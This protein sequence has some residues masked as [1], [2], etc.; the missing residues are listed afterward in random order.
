MRFSFFSCLA[1]LVSH[2]FIICKSQAL[3]FSLDYDNFIFFHWKGGLTS[4]SIILKVFPL[5]SLLDNVLLQTFIALYTK[6]TSSGVQ[7]PIVIPVNFENEEFPV[8]KIKLESLNPNTKYFYSFIFAQSSSF[9]SQTFAQIYLEQTPQEFSFHTLGA[10]FSP[11]NFTF[12]S[13]SC[14]DT[15][16][17]SSIFTTLKNLDLQFF[18][19]LG[20]LHYMNIHENEPERF[21]DAYYKVFS[22]KTQK[23]FLQSTPIFYVWDDH[24]FGPD[25]SNGTSPARPASTTAY[26]KFVPYDTLKNY[27]PIDISSVSLDDYLPPEPSGP[28]GIFRSFVVGRCLFIMMDL[29]SFKDIKPLD[30]LGPEQTVWL[31]NQLK[32]AGKNPH[33]L[34]AFLISSFSWIHI[35]GKTEWRPYKDVQEQISGWIEEYIYGNGKQIMMISGDAHMLALDDGTNNIY[36]HFPVIQT[37][38]LDSV[39][40]CKGG[41]YSHGL[42]SG[43]EHFGLIQVVD[44]GADKICIKINLKEREESLI[45]YD[46]CNKE[47]YPPNQK[48]CPI[49][50]P[51][52]NQKKTSPSWRFFIIAVVISAIVLLF[53]TYKEANPGNEDGRN[54][55]SY[56]EMTVHP[57]E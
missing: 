55:G 42:F 56:V 38:S 26:K 14:A 28:Y 5:Q 22:S 8:A 7:D 54:R 9:D 18:L 51:V 35:D 12:A 47:L 6:P 34:Q 46:T 41:P 37:A 36:G 30:V 24:D 33:I 31:E 50:T 25:N 10:A 40:S 52:V 49:V 20:D 17:N 39:P 11:Y 4:S 57:K 29:R 3:D 2:V 53:K 19:H 15:G 13:S 44:D 27:L 32:F 23:P 45:V 1:F 48:S 43:I 21:Y 16:S